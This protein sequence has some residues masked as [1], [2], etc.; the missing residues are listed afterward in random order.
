MSPRL[1]IGRLII[2]NAD[3]MWL[4]YFLET[5]QE[6]HNATLLASIKVEL[7]RDSEVQDAFFNLVRA[8]V[9]NYL[10]DRWG[11]AAS[12]GPAEDVSEP[13]PPVRVVN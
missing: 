12:Y 2:A 4:A 5:G 10:Q 1:E 3:G 6:F 11:A 8:G 7:V 13:D 9:A